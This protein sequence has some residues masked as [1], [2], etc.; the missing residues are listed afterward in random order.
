MRIP[1]LF[2]LAACA[3]WT[4][5]VWSCSCGYASPRRALAF[6]DVVFAGK[7]EEVAQVD[8]D[9]HEPRIR[10]RFKVGRVFKGPVGA[11]FTMHT[12]SE[13]STCNGFFRDLAKVGEELLVFANAQPAK[14][15]KLGEIAEVAADN[16]N[17]YTRRG[18]G[19]T[20]VLR[21]D[22]LDAVKADATIYGTDICSGTMRWEDAG[23]AV[24]SL[25]AY[26]APKGA[27]PMKD[28]PPFDESSIPAAMRGIAPVCWRI[29]NWEGWKRL[30]APPTEAP[31]LEALL[32]E[33]VRR[34][35]GEIGNQSYKDV[36]WREPD[37][38]QK[39]SRKP[40]QGRLAVCRMPAAGEFDACGAMSAMFDQP[41]PTESTHLYWAFESDPCDPA[42]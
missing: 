10:V 4:P 11:D 32:R 14:A 15:W 39:G 16:V 5:R 27:F 30:D 12:Y 34:V 40:R 2:L 36:W 17:S 1:L 31:R 6:A 18:E 19:A 13:F 42:Q 28:A 21:Q 25:G 41:L 9:S 8:K 37:Q 29:A 35:G 20:T 23:F 7:I 22:V 33:R 24:R 3:L 38:E 26:L